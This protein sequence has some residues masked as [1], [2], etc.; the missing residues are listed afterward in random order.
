[1]LEDTSC[2]IKPGCTEHPPWPGGIC[3]KCQ[4]SAITLKRQVNSGSQSNAAEKHHEIDNRKQSSKK[5]IGIKTERSRAVFQAVAVLITMATEIAEKVANLMMSVL[6]GSADALSC[7]FF[8]RPCLWSFLSFSEIMKH[9]LEILFMRHFL[10]NIL[11]HPG[12][13]GIK[14]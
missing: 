10:Y 13:S 6:F 7:S 14:P 11:C 4:P 1:M 9:L 5:N 8:I 2:R 12:F 3:T